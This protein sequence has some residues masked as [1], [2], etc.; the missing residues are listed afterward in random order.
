MKFSDQ[1]ASID[2]EVVLRDVPQKPAQMYYGSADKI[3]LAA[4][5]PLTR[6]RCF[7]MRLRPQDRA[8]IDSLALRLGTSCS[9]VVR[10]AVCRLAAEVEQQKSAKNKPPAA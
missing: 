2:F 10:R 9:D 7:S 3:D 4:M 5:K 1:I 6:S 8:L